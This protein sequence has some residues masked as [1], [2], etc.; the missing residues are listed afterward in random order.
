MLVLNKYIVSFLNEVCKEIKYHGVHKNISEEIQ[1]HIDEIADQ[2]IEN[3]M[4]EEQAIQRAIV[5]MG[6][7]AEIGK[8]LNKTHRPKTE[9]S[10]L[11]LIGAM[12]SIG[13]ITLFALANDA[14]FSS[15]EGFLVNYL[16]YTVMG[17]VALIGCFFF[18]YT[19]LEKYSMYIFIGTIVC[20]GIYEGFVLGVFTGTFWGT[21]VYGPYIRLGRF[22]FSTIDM[23]VLIF[24][25]SFSGI[26]NKWATGDIKNMI[27]LLALAAMAC[28]LMVYLSLAR[29]MLLSA[30]FLVMITKAILDKEFNGSKKGYLLSIYGGG[31]TIVCAVLIWVY[32]NIGIHYRADR[33]AVFLNPQ[34]DPLGAGYV[35]ALLKKLLSNA[36]LFGANDQLYL[37]QGN[38]PRIALPE[39]NTDF[40]FTYIVSAFGWIAGIITIMVIV[41]AIVRMFLATRKIN[42]PYGR[43]LASAIVTIF[44]LQAVANILMNMGMFP[45]T[46]FSLPFISYG[47]SNFVVNMALVGLLLSVYRRKDLLI[48]KEGY[49]YGVDH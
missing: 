37:M 8:E 19:K 14:A 38:T 4:E 34:L 22:A 43:Y 28:I 42:H 46:S 40:I 17:F 33:V 12:V 18:D 36:K 41:L 13:G 7:P 6:D 29:A 9:W 45:I 3:G 27:K 2:Y 30:G 20:L 23:I 48:R 16:I 26:V 32:R 1:G 11:V 24:I 25:V 39:A 10:I 44:S 31:I 47:G 49:Q 15:F 21:S 5:Q 35:D